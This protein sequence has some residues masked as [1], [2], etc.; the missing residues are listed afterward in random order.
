MPTRTITQDFCDVC[1]ADEPSTES[2]AH[3][4]IRF[5]WQGT[6]YVLLA[7]ERHVGPIREQLQGW[8]DIASPGSGRGAGRGRS[9][10]GGSGGQTLFSRLSP[11]DKAKFRAWADMPSARRIADTRVQEWLDAGRP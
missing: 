10:A 11:E 9:T 8:A 3:E 7:C 1:F 5:S 4:R 2:E 6:P